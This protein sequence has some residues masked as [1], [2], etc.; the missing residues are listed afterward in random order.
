VKPR[1][2][3]AF[4]DRDG[5]IN[6]ER[7]RVHRVDDFVLLPGAVQ[8]LRL[9]RDAGFRLVVVSNQAGIAR[10][11]YDVAAVEAVHLHLR[12]TLQTEGLH[13]DRIYYCPHHPDGRVPGLATHCT[14]RK[15][16]PGLL[17]Q[18]SNDLGLDLASSVLIGD[19]LSDIQAGRR[20]GVATTVLVESGHAPT[21]EA[22][23][24]A[25]LV[26]ADL[27]AAALALLQPDGDSR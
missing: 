16:A 17:L 1:S 4:V 24:L 20:A 7:H 25:D 14:C 11:L 27:L 19:Q 13:L 23:L 15:P 8:G 12:Q 9:L 6:E 5:V 10:D 26:T 18:A 21:P 3:A 22:R 2:K